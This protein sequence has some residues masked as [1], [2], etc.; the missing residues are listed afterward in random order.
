MYVFFALLGAWLLF[1]HSSC[2]TFRT[3]DRKWPG[4]LQEKGQW[5]AP[6]FSDIEAPEIG[7]RV[8]AVSLGASDS[9]PVVVLLHGSPGSSN[10]FLPLLAD[11]ALSREARLISL[12][13]PGF[14]YTSGFGRAE[15]S[16]AAQAKAIRAVL[17]SL[18][19]GR[20]VVLVGHSLGGPIITRFAMDYPER[21][22]AL[23]IVAGNL[24]PALEPKPWWQG[25]VDKPP[26]RWLLPRTFVTSN[27]EIIPQR[28]ELREILPRWAEVRCPVYIVHAEDDRLVPVGNAGF[29]RDKLV[30]A[31][32]VDLNILPKGDH[33]ILWTR[34]ELMRETLLKAIREGQAYVQRSDSIGTPSNR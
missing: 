8:H 27:R 28:Q 25:M 5:L 16:M 15:G 29:A 30:N 31:A 4:K 22:A 19:P 14:G 26:V 9:L 20:R 23:M 18:A 17:D 11:T 13:R 10:A 6:R 21:T 32:K 34:P 12:D 24:D 33:F 2:M 1:A 3:P 7:R